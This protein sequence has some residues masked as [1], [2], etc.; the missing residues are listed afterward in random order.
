MIPSREPKFAR[1]ELMGY[2]AAVMI[3]KLRVIGYDS[4]FGDDP[5]KLAEEHAE[6]FNAAHEAAMRSV[7]A[8]YVCTKH[9]KMFLRCISCEEEAIEAARAEVVAKVRDAVDV[10]IDKIPI[11]DRYSNKRDGAILMGEHILE[12]IRQRGAGK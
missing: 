11:A 1:V 8:E 4:S 3:G 2:E 9:H 5:V 6:A 7:R 10:F 12:A